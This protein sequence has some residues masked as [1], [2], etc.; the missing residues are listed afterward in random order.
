MI[1][2]NFFPKSDMD[3]SYDHHG[4][5]R[6]KGQDWLHTWVI[7][8]DGG[9]SYFELEYDADSHTFVEFHKHGEA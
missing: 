8:M 3:D 5:L 2:A 1:Y 9:D 4:N 6:F 7:V